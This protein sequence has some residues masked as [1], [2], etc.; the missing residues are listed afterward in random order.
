MCWRRHRG[1]G[2]GGAIFS[3]IGTVTVRNIG[4][5]PQ[6]FSDSSQKLIDAGGRQFGSD[7]SAAV[8]SLSQEKTLLTTI[9]P[10]NS[11]TGTLVFD[12]PTDVKLAA[13]ELHD[14]PFSGGTK[15][16]LAG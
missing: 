7:S 2:L 3:D 1:A 12:V 15:V 4:T 9:N 16:T 8:I 11:V 14:S 6:M 13:I 5:A 10:G